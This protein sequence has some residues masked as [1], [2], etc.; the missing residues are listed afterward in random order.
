VNAPLYRRLI[1][2]EQA[3]G[4]RRMAYRAYATR[5]DADAASDSPDGATTVMRIITGVP[6]SPAWPPASP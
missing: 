4:R 3:A 5:A 1:A 2:L 6:R